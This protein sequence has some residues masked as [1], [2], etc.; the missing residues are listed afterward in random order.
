M[1]GEHIQ[2]QNDTQEV[3]REG[4]VEAQLVLEDGTV[5]QGFS[6]GS[7]RSTAGEAVF[8]T[9]MV[10]YPEA[11]TDPSYEGQI[12]TLTY[13]LV[14]NYGAPGK[15]AD[16][17]GLPMKLES[18]RIHIAALVCQEYSFVYSHWQATQSLRDWLVAEDVPAIFGIDT[19]EVTKKIRETGCMLA[20]IL[21]GKDIQQNTIEFY[22]PNDENLVAKV[23]QR[24]VKT[25]NPPQGTATR[26]SILCVDVGMKYNQIRCFVERGAKV[27][28]VPWDHAFAQMMA[29]DDYDGLF[30]SNGPGDPTMCDATIENVK[31]VIEQNKKLSAPKPIFGICLGHQILSLAAGAET[32]KM[33]FGNRGHNIPCLDLR[34]NRCYITTQNHGFHVEESTLPQDWLPLFRN[35]NDQT[36]EGVPIHGTCPMFVET[37]HTFLCNIYPSLH[38]RFVSVTG[39]SIGQA[40]EFDYSGSQCIKALKEEGIETVLINSN[41]ATNQTSKGLAD[42]V[43]FLPVTPEY[44]LKVIREEKP[45][46]VLVTFGGQTA[47][48]C[49]IAI[50]Q[51]LIDMG[52]A[53]LGTPI[54]T[55]ED[56]EDRER[57]N[58]ILDS[59]NE[60][61]AVSMAADNTKD[62]I[63]G[64]NEIGYP[65]IVRAAF[66][67]GGLGSGFANNDKEMRALV[68][69]ALNTSPQVLVERS[70]KGWKEV[71]YE[72]VR[73][74]Y[75]NC[76]TV[77]NMENFDP[78]GI[79]TG[80]SIVVAPSQTLSDA[81]Y[82]MLRDTAVKV[83]RRLGVV[84]ECNIQ[85]A[86]NPNNM[87]YCI[88]EVNARLS[89]SSA[90][91]SKATG[92]PLAYVAAKLALNIP[93]PE[94]LNQVTKKTCACF[95]PSLDY[96]VVK[97]PRWDLRKFDRVST[98]VGSAMKSVGEVMSIAR[99]FEE[100]M[101]KAVRCV[102]DSIP[103]FQA[104]TAM[105]ES[106][107]E[108]VADLL[109]NATDKR[110]FY[111][112][113]A[114]ERGWTVDRVWELTKIDKWFLS[115]LS[116]IVVYRKHLERIGDAPK[117]THANVLRAKQLG[118]SDRQ[119]AEYCSSTEMNVR[120][121]RSSM[122][123]MPW[124]KQIDT[125]AAEFPCVTNYLYSTY[126]ASYHD[127]TFNDHGV[128]M[129]GSGV[130]R[131]GSSVEFDWCAVSAIKAL[132]AEGLKTIMLNY[133]PETVST[134]FD[135][136]D[137]LYFGNISVETVVDIY[138]MESSAGVFISMGG[139]A[140]NNIAM[141]LHRNGVKIF[142][143][144]PT[145]IDQAEN[146]YKFSR[147]LDSMGVD[148]PR[149]RE[150]TS[151][152]EA[153]SF[154]NEVSF[155]VLVRPSYVLSG[156]AMNV[157]HTHDDLQEYLGQA[158]EV[159][160]EHPVV[161]SKFIENA[162]EIEM[163]AVAKDG[164]LIMH[165]ISEHVENAGVHSGDA[166]LIQPPQDLDEKTMSRIVAATA[167]IAQGLRVTGPMNIQFIAKDQTIKVIECNVRAS[168]SFPFVSKTLGVNLIEMA[169][170]AMIGKD[171][172]PYPNAGRPKLDYCCIKVPQFSFNR[173]SG[174]DPIMGVEMASTGEI[175]CFGRNKHEAY[176][177]G[178]TAVGFKIPKV[179]NVLLSIGSF[180]EKNEFLPCVRELVE[181]GW[182][183]YAS[184]G[185]GDFLTEHGITVKVLDHI[186][187]EFEHQEKEE[188]SISHY[189]RE[190]KIGLYVCL[191]SRNKY[192]RPASYISRGY[193]TRRMAVDF[194]VP[195][196]TNIKCAKLFVDAIYKYPNIADLPLGAHDV[197][198]SLDVKSLP[199]LVDV[200]VQPE[201]LNKEALTSL[202]KKCLAA[203]IT[204]PCFA[205]SGNTSSVVTAP[206]FTDFALA[207]TNIEDLG[208]DMGANAL[209]IQQENVN[210]PE[211]FTGLADVPADVAL[212]SNASGNT[213]AS[214]LFISQMQG[215]AVHFSQVSRADD[216]NLI[217]AAKDNMCPV[218]CDVNPLL[219]SLSAQDFE[220][221]TGS[222]PTL[223]NYLA[224]K[225]ACA[226]T[227]ADVDTIKSN[228]HLVD[229][230]S[231]GQCTDHLS[232]VVVA[233]LT[234]VKNGLL[235]IEEFQV[236]YSEMPRRI[237]RL[238]PATPAISA[239]IAVDS[240]NSVATSGIFSDRK[241]F[242]RVRAVK[243]NN[244]IIAE[245][246]E[247]VGQP[248]GIYRVAM[249]TGAAGVALNVSAATP[250][251]APTPKL[252]TESFP[253][254]FMAE[255]ESPSVGGRSLSQYTPNMTPKTIAASSTPAMTALAHS[256]ASL[257]HCL[258]INQF[259]RKY[260]HNLF[261]VASDM[262]VM[263][264]RTGKIDLL[265]GKVLACVFYEASTRTSTSFQTA[266]L[267]LGGQVVNVDSTSSSV[268][269]GESLEDTIR[270]LECYADAIV[271]RHPTKGT[272]DV[273]ASVA[274]VPVINAGDGIGE[275]PTQALL[276]LYT[277]R[278]ELGT[279]NGLT[280][281]VIGDLKHGRT[282]HSLVK[283]LCHYQVNFIFVAEESLAMPEYVLD[284]VRAAGKKYTVTNDL[285]QIHQAD[286]WYQTR[287]QK[288]RFNSVSDYEACKGRFT[289][290]AQTLRIAK[291]K[292]CILHP[293]PRVDEITPEVD[294][295]P[296]AA[297]FR[298]MKYGLYVRMALLA[299]TMAQM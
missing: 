297:Y 250:G 62:A 243:L 298:Q 295:D 160:R 63:R 69:Q 242:G 285:Q 72:V 158:A 246:N 151:L 275:H 288:E 95:E 79:H 161:I 219:L 193:T 234:A 203:G 128:I 236:K 28:V 286:V 272:A 81:E 267:R 253:S 247:V 105:L 254:A 94:I 7:E 57:F 220:A 122:K 214:L 218:T 226:G 83:I 139:Q 10:G 43:Y 213:L 173:L 99:T 271:L 87:E 266:M 163:D 66:A 172:V 110:L 89:R 207:T 195:L 101:Q 45:D 293:L 67:L 141:T 197:I 212:I 150:L 19:R 152:D 156:A 70:M 112:A 56:T 78:L 264:E 240:E 102:D 104:P 229:A 124:I 33:L 202:T 228:L 16:E 143:T 108:V 4:L 20:K 168:R 100:A 256:T 184:P 35:A 113:V 169:T 91:A 153:A 239:E 42:K 127:I 154:C 132:R 167:A 198:S 155:P 21:V 49:A 258:S 260:L 159:S 5:F 138:E 3:H 164:E 24:E 269:K 53:V 215:R 131:I 12:L 179:K 273:A 98:K 88:I 76:I 225:K 85:Y 174:A 279:I 149:W 249:A 13:P 148:Q 52:V 287:I 146:R 268:T 106:S 282:T 296:R 217:A 216:L 274:S 232:E 92:Y 1:P 55:I 251:P 208:A 73:D 283:L 25:Y 15:D 11:M 182:T 257:K 255:A 126:N 252:V 192:R 177:K 200:A 115:K 48:N 265:S 144:S 14:G 171:V 60:K 280:I 17:T 119:I 103:G 185:T 294:Y 135:E 137:R 40:G 6:F 231:A 123:I 36:N 74:C 181:T 107:D 23:S 120:K 299:V 77:C 59:I 80:D 38:L 68:D 64:A 201:T 93:L 194:Q 289:I 18:E 284:A 90:L 27:T 261:Q 118:F 223:L 86:L 121:I 204:L 129:L 166:T 191:P 145:Q 175:G 32:S 51:D 188:F 41:I 109:E 117:L 130:Y 276:D 245:R 30:I 237:L 31:Q 44:V 134:D 61:T 233:A 140:P 133:N 190:S 125:V 8:Q 2:N 210:V 165:V 180:Q 270:C 189:L 37:K 71:E 241:T 206:A 205:A 82:N 54:P 162:K 29:T 58:E 97:I 22:N 84:G 292:M 26:A 75:D 142:G 290:S 187:G 238:A 222:T 235:T 196:I 96:C 39:L 259:D 281:A 244:S 248:T 211:L 170:L 291:E 147:L 209:F 136:V 199:G 221:T 183:I 186:F 227:W 50:Q 262:R 263:V 230:F 176:L 46:G 224:S 114:L 277:I 9:G 157:V 278:E 47:L 178:L 111:V 34:S 116:N 65:V